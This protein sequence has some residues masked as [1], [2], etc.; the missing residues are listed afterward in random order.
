MGKSAKIQTFADDWN[1]YVSVNS[2]YK[3]I[4]N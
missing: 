2:K 1:F 3:Q 4:G